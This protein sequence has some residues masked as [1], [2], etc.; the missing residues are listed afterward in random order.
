MW[1]SG[2]DGPLV[3]GMYGGVLLLVMAGCVG[4]RVVMY[5]SYLVASF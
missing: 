2:I 3:V 4:A 5:F 1:V